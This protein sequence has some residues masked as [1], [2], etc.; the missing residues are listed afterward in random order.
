MSACLGT[1]S[2][3]LLI[4]GA[5]PVLLGPLVL[6]HR[7]N[8]SGVGALVTIEII[9]IAAGSIAGPKLLRALSPRV[10]AL[11]CALLLAVTNALIVKRHGLGWLLPL[12]AVAGFAGGLLVSIAMVA[13]AH[14]AK[15]ERMSGIFLAVQT[16][17]QLVVAACIPSLLWNGSRADAGFVVLAGAA[18]P[19]L[20]LAPALPAQLRPADSTKSKAGI[21]LQAL[22]ALITAGM[23]L[24]A[25]VAVWGY[26]GVWLGQH[27][28]AP[29][30]EATAVSITL[31]FQVLGALAAVKWSDSLPD[32][33]V[34]AGA[35]VAEALIAIG[36]LSASGQ[37]LV[38]Y[39]ASAAFGF[40]WLFTLPSFTGLLIEIDPARRAV[41]YV[42]AAQ[43]TGAAA[44]PTLA[45]MLVTDGNVENAFVL[46]IATFIVMSALSLAE[47]VLRKPSY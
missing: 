11:A 40:I 36:M 1:G 2:I 41:L 42:V 45:A 7:I 46:A 10:V 6:E 22:V 20:L 30:V 5:Q 31:L 13:I 19:T 26:L 25:I 9:A 32:R 18:I 23:F 34:I 27:G 21:S 38:I 15:P 16:L 4:L 29:S 35:A 14:S 12:R 24:G 39:I 43:L 28:H 44:L 8:D 33:G 37:P 47:R 17:L 3:G